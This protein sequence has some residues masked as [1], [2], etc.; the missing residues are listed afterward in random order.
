MSFLL[1][2]EFPF[3]PPIILLLLLFY[4]YAFMFIILCLSNYSPSSSQGIQTLD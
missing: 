3:L 4:F 1:Y 2:Y